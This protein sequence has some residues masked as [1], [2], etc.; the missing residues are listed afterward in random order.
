[1][2][3][4]ISFNF[5]YIFPIGIEVP[6]FN[7]LLSICVHFLEDMSNN[8]IIYIHMKIQPFISQMNTLS[9]EPFIT[10]L[11]SNSMC[12]TSEAMHG[13]TQTSDSTLSLWY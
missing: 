7:I 5:P 11:F 9:G 1:M 4:S 2:H 13:N 6:P 8:S 12:E 3:H 10:I